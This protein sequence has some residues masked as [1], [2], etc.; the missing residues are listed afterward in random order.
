MVQSD[1]ARIGCLWRKLAGKRT[2]GERRDLSA[3]EPG[4]LTSFMSKEAPSTRV[5][6]ASTCFTSRRK[7]TWRYLSHI[8]C[9]PADTQLPCTDIANAYYLDVN[10]FS[11]EDLARIAHP[12]RMQCTQSALNSI[13]RSSFPFID[14]NPVMPTR[15]NT[16]SGA[17]SNFFNAVRPGNNNNLLTVPT[18]AKLT[19]QASTS[20]MFL[21]STSLLGE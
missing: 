2:A 7:T 18:P 10:G 21:P 4:G 5:C 1:K 11:H 19:K 14:P 9:I 12:R 15:K 3:R 17:V 20:S 13:T 16:M 8:L 6:V